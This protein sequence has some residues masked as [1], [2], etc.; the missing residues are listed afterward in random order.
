MKFCTILDFMHY[1]RRYQI[2]SSFYRNLPFNASAFS[3]S[4][5]HMSSHRIIITFNGYQGNWIPNT[6]PVCPHTW[7]CNNSGTRYA[8]HGNRTRA[9]ADCRG[10][11]QNFGWIS[12]RAITKSIK[13]QHNDDQRVDA[14]EGL[15][16]MSDYVS[17][18]LH[19]RELAKH[20]PNLRNCNCDC[21]RL[22]LIYR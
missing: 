13:G 6:S 3:T 14:C 4:Y 11:Y 8:R 10:K 15:N 16:K 5:V 1:V 18:T 12:I 21:K 19:S 2:T 7:K 9:L 20:V 17:D 22:S